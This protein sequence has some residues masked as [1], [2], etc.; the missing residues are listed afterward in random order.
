VFKRLT[1]LNCAGCGSARACYSLLHGRVL[2]AMNYNIL[3]V[4]FLPVM[5]W[6]FLVQFTGRGLRVW[7]KISKPLPVLII[8]CV[9]WILRNIDAYPLT[10]LHA[11]K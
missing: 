5:A 8:I 11:D 4:L 6:G 2:Q 10:W 9:F 7:N 1:G 3:M